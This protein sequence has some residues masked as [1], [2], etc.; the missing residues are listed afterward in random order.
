MTNNKIYI[1]AVNQLL[2]LKA[3]EL[4]KNNDRDAACFYLVKK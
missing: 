4:N 1:Q 3:K 2:W